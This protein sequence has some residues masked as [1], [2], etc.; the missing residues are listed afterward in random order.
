[1]AQRLGE[2][3]LALA[4]QNFQKNVAQFALAQRNFPVCRSLVTLGEFI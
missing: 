4:Q 1:V 3:I 2:K